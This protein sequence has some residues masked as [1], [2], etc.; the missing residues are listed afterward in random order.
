MIEA[1][2]RA[3]QP[4]GSAPTYVFQ[5]DWQTPI[6]GGKWKAHHGLDVP[7]IF[8]NAA[9]TPHLV[10]TGADPLGARRR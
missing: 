2:R 3:A 10:G 7:F 4:A 6:D 9:I 1:D 5:F 8:D